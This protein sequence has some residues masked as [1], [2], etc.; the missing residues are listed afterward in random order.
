M[1][2]QELVNYNY[3]ADFWGLYISGL[4]NAIPTIEGLFKQA[5]ELTKS[6]AFADTEFER[7]IRQDLLNAKKEMYQVIEARTAFAVWLNSLK[8]VEGVI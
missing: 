5:F 2:G 1:K 8:K 6:K 7:L 3:C 4:Q